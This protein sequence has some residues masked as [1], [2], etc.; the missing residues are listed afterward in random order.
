MMKDMKDTVKK[1]LDDREVST[2]SGGLGTPEEYRRYSVPDREGQ[3]N[4]NGGEQDG[5]AGNTDVGYPFIIR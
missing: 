3:Q 5:T 4:Q 1:E 2:V